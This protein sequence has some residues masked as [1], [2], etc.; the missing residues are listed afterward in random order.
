MKCCGGSVG[1]GVV[2]WWGNKGALWWWWRLQESCRQ[3]LTMLKS[4]LTHTRPH[5]HTCTYTHKYTPV[6]TIPG[7]RLWIPT[8]WMFA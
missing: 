5:K 1:A 4:A 6:V 3:L 2:T 7:L 8:F